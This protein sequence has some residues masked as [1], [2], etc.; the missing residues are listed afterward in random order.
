MPDTLQIPVS[1][2]LIDVE[3]PR[4][5]Q[6]NVGQ[7]EAQREFARLQQ[8]KLLVLALDIVKHGLNLADLPIVRPFDERR[9]VV[10]E[11]NRRLVAIKAL[12]N[13]D[14][15]VGAFTPVVLNAM[16]K[17]SI[18]YQQDPIE[19]INCL[20]VREKLDAEHWIDLRHSGQ[21][22]GAGII[23]W[24]ADEAARFRSRKSIV[25][26]HIQALDFLEDKGYLTPEKRREIPAA[27]LER[28]MSSPAVREKVGVNVKKKQLE[29]LG[30]EKQVA[31]ALMYVVNDLA[32]GSKKT[33]HIYTKDDREKYANELPASIVV[34]PT[35]KGGQGVPVGTPAQPTPQ[36]AAAVKLPKQRGKLIPR[37][38]VL[39]VTD[40]RI[41][42]IEAELR[43]LS[44]EDYTNAVS[45]LFRVFIELSADSYITKIGLSTSILKD[46]L[47][48]K[49]LDVANDLVNRQKLTRE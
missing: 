23:P 16:R 40:P 12:E 25:P 29:I 5:P 49:I 47:A 33:R 45:V 7:R 2:L 17:L 41:K 24:G 31:K 34:T 15:M 22:K 20:V 21:M 18:E 27:S 1:D 35:A 9:Y 37:D 46:S 26:P 19:S 39:S 11:G 38:C 36:R 42:R 6:P 3:N 13:P 30:N 43:N 28:L 10:L 14:S 4:L 32:S 44:L 8:D 48:T